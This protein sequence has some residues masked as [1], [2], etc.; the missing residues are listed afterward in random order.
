MAI[1]EKEAGHNQKRIQCEVR[2]Q[3]QNTGI[4]TKTNFRKKNSSVFMG[5][6]GMAIEC[7]SKAIN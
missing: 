6:D 5:K 2:K 1:N 4:G 7:F 3:V